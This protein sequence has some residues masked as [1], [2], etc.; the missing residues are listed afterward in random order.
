[1]KKWHYIFL[2]CLLSPLKFLGQSP[3]HHSDERLL[4]LHRS[5][6]QAQN[7]TL[8]MDSYRELGFY[9]QNGNPDSALYY[10]Q[11]QLALAKKL[12]MKLWEADAY[13]QIGYVQI[14]LINFS[15]SLLSFFEAFKIAEDEESEK[16]VWKVSRFSFSKNPHE[17]RL[18]TL[19]MIH[20][21][22]HRLYKATGKTDKER[23][24]LFTD[25]RF[26]KLTQNKKL[27]I[28]S[29]RGLGEF[30]LNQ[31]ITDSVLHYLN[32]SRRY[33]KNSEYQ[34]QRGKLYEVL[35]NYYLR[36]Q[37]YDSAL[38]NYDTAVQINISQSQL[39]SLVLNSIEEGHPV[40]GG[41]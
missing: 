26:G 29:N 2:V 34:L 15:E 37:K 13:Q 27:L 16:N 11:L 6:N 17:A 41:S 36:V 21:D 35:G 39:Q 32:Q 5:R 3:E 19:G 30:Y 23:E 10:H 4:V 20:N 1:M 38:L 31:G 25:L 22:I 14:L 9:Y 33:Y 40:Q 12:K 7:D 24:S 8:R 18:A 28:L